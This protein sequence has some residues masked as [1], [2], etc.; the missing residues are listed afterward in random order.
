M[1]TKYM[2]TH[3][4]EQ[5]QRVKDAHNTLMQ[6]EGDGVSFT[7]LASEEDIVA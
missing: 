5:K 2:S 4:A 3:T 6:S 1:K 7:G